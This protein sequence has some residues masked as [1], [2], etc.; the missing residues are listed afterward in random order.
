MISS[1][2]HWVDFRQG[3]TIFLLRWQ[4][5]IIFVEW[6]SLWQTHPW[7]MVCSVKT[8][9]WLSDFLSYPPAKS[10]ETCTA[11]WILGWKVS[12][13][14]IPTDN[15]TLCETCK[16]TMHAA[17]LLFCQ[18]EYFLTLGSIFPCKWSALYSQWLCQ[19]PFITSFPLCFVTTQ[20]VRYSVWDFQCRA[21]FC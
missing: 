1:S 9:R 16:T 10:S 18:L 14:P 8:D 7:L 21:Q 19:W 6:A 4:L 3:Q 11:V 15:N 12:W 2:H 17:I 5:L 13:Q 20:S